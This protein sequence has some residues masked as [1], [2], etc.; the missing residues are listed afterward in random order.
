MTHLVLDR[1]AMRWSIPAGDVA[2]ELGDRPLVVMLHG[3]GSFEGDLLPIVAH[4]P[5]HA[6]VVSVRAPLAAGSG[7]AWFPLEFDPVTGLL[8]RDPLDAD[9]TAS[10]L[11]AWLA[12][13][14]TLA[15]HEFP[16]AL[17]GFSQG[18]AMA[19][20]VLRHAPER[21]SA[22]V[23]FAGF[24]VDDP[25]PAARERD[26]ALALVHPPVFWGRDPQ[27]PVI[28]PELIASTRRWLPAHCDTDARLYPHIG[29]GLS[30]DEV[31]DAAEFLVAHLL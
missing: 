29:H 21:F 24:V 20:H 5:A 15:G 9:A 19:L 14:E 25:S 2:R 22:V 12:E 6:V 16:V 30:L 4:L 3:Y 1:E 13:L 23:S 10:L 31:Q 28:T 18:G 17:L 26:A 11:L 7:F 8:H 27:D